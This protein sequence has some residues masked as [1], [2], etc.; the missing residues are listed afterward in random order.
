MIILRII[1]LVVRF[2]GGIGILRTI[3]IVLLIIGLIL[4]VLGAVGHAARGHH[5]AGESPDP[6]SVRRKRPVAQ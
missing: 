5:T 6:G 2:F 3:G 1:Q 4:W